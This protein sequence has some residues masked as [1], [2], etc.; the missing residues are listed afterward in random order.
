MVAYERNIYPTKLETVR[1]PTEKDKIKKNVKTGNQ[2][3]SEVQCPAMIKRTTQDSVKISVNENDKKEPD[4]AYKDFLLLPETD[5]V[6]LFK[7][8][9]YKIPVPVRL[10]S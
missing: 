1:K 6:L 10:K 8:E 7:K 3:Q 5:K 2:I 9:Y 4:E